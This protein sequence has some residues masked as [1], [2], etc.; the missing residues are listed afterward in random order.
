MTLPFE[1]N[2]STPLPKFTGNRKSRRAL[3]KAAPTRSAGLRSTTINYLL[4]PIEPRI[5]LSADPMAVFLNGEMGED[6]EAHVAATVR[7]FSEDN[8]FS[9]Y[10]SKYEVRDTSTNVIL[11]EATQITSTSGLDFLSGS[12]DDAIS[13]EFAD[14]FVFDRDFTVSVNGGLGTDTVQVTSF[15]AGYLGSLNIAAET[16]EVSAEIGSVAQRVNNVTINADR[17]SLFPRQAMPGSLLRHQTL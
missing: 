7:L 13:L 5:L 17:A 10:V 3:A 6:A 2:T 12:G 8:G 4:D 1:N 11:V 16:V 15:V 9:S 14:S